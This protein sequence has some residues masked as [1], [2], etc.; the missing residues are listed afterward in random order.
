MLSVQLAGPN[1]R[2]RLG[3]QDQPI[4]KRWKLRLRERKAFAEVTQPGSICC[5]DLLLSREDFTDSCPLPLVP[6]SQATPVQH[7]QT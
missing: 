4:L 5:Q 2:P 7:D 1:T 6:Q 3:L